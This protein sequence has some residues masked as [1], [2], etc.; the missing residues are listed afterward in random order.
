MPCLIKR[1]TSTMI[2]LVESFLYPDKKGTIEQ[3]RGYSGQKSV[4]TYYNKDEN[5]SPKNHNQKNW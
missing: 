2:F 5:N 1:Q 3:P 4:L